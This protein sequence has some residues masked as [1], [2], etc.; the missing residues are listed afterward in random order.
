MKI[1]QR[2]RR[3]GFTL[4]ELLVVMAIIAT[5]AGISFAA[6]RGILIGARQKQ[7][8]IIIQSISDAMDQRWSDGVPFTTASGSQSGEYPFPSD[9]NAGVASSALLLEALRNKYEVKNNGGIAYLPEV[10]TPKNRKY[11]GQEGAKTVMLDGFGKPLRYRF[12]GNTGKGKMN[13]FVG[14]FDLWS[15]GPD[16]VDNGGKGDDITNWD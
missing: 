13:N 16:G 7:T 9:G 14:G 2:Q 8:V 4:M 15:V 11:L 6:Y 5:L 3:S 1:T 12:N 10:D